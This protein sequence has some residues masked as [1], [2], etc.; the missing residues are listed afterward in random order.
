MS[1]RDYFHVCNIRDLICE[2]ESFAREDRSKL[3]IFRAMERSMSLIG[4]SS[5]QLSEAFKAGHPE[6]SWQRIASLRHRLVHE[7]FSIDHDVLWRI[8]E[9]DVPVLK[10]HITFILAQEGKRRK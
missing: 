2:V 8:V 3:Y 9:E 5:Y 10:D 6:V 1:E 7:Y 4:E